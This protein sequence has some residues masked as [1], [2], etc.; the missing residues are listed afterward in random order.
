M[1]TQTP[2]QTPGRPSSIRN[3][4]H[5]KLALLS[6]IA[7]TAMLAQTTKEQPVSKAPAN[8]DDTI[9]LDVFTVSAA[10][11]EGFIATQN[12]SGGR[13]ATEL[14]ETPIAY[15]VQ[16]RDFLDALNISNLEDALEWSV[17]TNKFVNVESGGIALGGD[18]TYTTRGFSANSSQRNFFSGSYNSDTYNIERFDYA[19]G[20]NSTMF[21]A[22]TI[23][24]TANSM[25]KFARSDK[26][27][28][29]EDFV[30][31]DR[32]SVRMSVDAN[33]KIS[34]GVGARINALWSEQQGWRDYEVRKSRGVAPSVS[35]KL[36]RNSEFRLSGEYFE[37]D[38]F[39]PESPLR[40]NL[41]GWDGVTTFDGLV[42]SGVSLGK[43]G[44]ARINGSGSTAQGYEYWMF[45]QDNTKLMNYVGM[46]NSIAWSGNANRAITMPDGSSVTATGG[47]MSLAEMPFTDRFY[48][49]LSD[50]QLFGPAI[51]GSSFR[52]PSRS[53]TN[54]PSTPIGTDR[55][56]DLTAMFTH[57]IGD[58]NLM[59]AGN[60]NRLNRYGN[61]SFYYNN[62]TYDGYG[63][64][65]IDL[66]KKQPDG[67]ANPYFLKTYSRARMD[68]SI[69]QNDNRTVR[70]SVAYIKSLRWVDLSL[71]GQIGKEHT[72]NLSIREN[73]VVGVDADVR[74]WGRGGNQSRILHFYMYEDQ[75]NRTPPS[76][77][78][79]S[80]TA[81]NPLTGVTTD[82]T[83]LWVLATSRSST[84]SGVQKQIRDVDYFQYFSQFG[85]FKR[86]VVLTLAYRI[87]QT[88]SSQKFGMRAMSYPTGFLATAGNYLFRPD[89]PSDYFDLLYTPANVAGVATGQKTYAITRPVDSSTGIPLAQYANDRF[90][91][92]YNAPAVTV[93]PTTKNVGFVYQP[94]AKLPVSVFTNYSQSYNPPA[95]GLQTID[96][97]TP[98]PSNAEEIAW[99]LRTGLGSNKFVVTLTRYSSNEK[100]YTSTNPAGYSNLNTI[101]TANAKGDLSLSGINARDFPLVPGQWADVIGN[102]KS[103]GWELEVDANV[104]RGLRVKFNGSMN[105]SNNIDANQDTRRYI[106]TNKESLRQIVLDT[107]ATMVGDVASQGS[108]STAVSPDI[109]AAVNAWN[110]LI[111]NRTNSYMSGSQKVTRSMR[112]QFN[113]YSDY[114]FKS[115]SLKGFKA[116]L[117]WQF[118]GPQVIGFRGSDQ[119]EV[120]V[121]GV[122]T[123]IDDPAVNAYNR[124]YA[125]SYGVCNATLSYSFK[126]YKKY[127]IDLQ[128][129]IDNLLNYDYPI[130]NSTGARPY[131]QDITSPARVYG[132]YLAYTYITPRTFTLRSTIRF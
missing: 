103:Q 122:R 16:T 49:P 23:S 100:N 130:Y 36:G 5:A 74:Q 37:K 105:D 71:N 19:R 17:N 125:R 91:D 111:K 59:V 46:V 104:I 70:A 119:I 110:D 128:L 97:G 114:A 95:L 27:F 24:G 117:G 90:R 58:F 54:L 11:D 32:G 80:I 52:M 25:T 81:V 102:R 2:D 48:S 69:K 121:N 129:S 51:R 124:V 7:T 31:D 113:I 21:G 79:E 41:S 9:Q 29:R 34:K 115:D 63:P 87:D 22:G 42:A 62:G 50:E 8:E 108:V 35:I 75:T 10:K 39:V 64:L 106:D 92:D 45:S 6:V 93:K 12:L 67:S 98:S 131:N 123:A 28:S 1:H 57:R 38:S 3:R 4:T 15:T 82:Y 14:S 43:V 94:I 44:A 109:I 40:D 118:K 126:G 86:R 77:D 127:P 76:L 56:K 66:N 84:D 78:G 65:Y 26:S 53:A 112:Y 72:E 33:K 18:I 13:L 107:G 30:I 132:S 73:G 60:V 99:G 47:S 55:F 88:T 96:Y 85:F 20:P 101:I 120:T 61:A 116:G 83:P 68:R 89:A